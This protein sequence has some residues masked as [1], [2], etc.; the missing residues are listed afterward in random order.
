MRCI[1]KVILKLKFEHESQHQFQFLKS[2]LTFISFS[3]LENFREVH[4]YLFV[5]SR[6]KETKIYILSDDIQ[7]KG[8]RRWRPEKEKSSNVSS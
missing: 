6:C 7:F 8:R 4:D 3:Q 2:I 5:N 1:S